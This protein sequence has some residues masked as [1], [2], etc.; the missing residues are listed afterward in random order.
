MLAESSSTP[1]QYG[2][3]IDQ[4][5]RV[6]PFHPRVQAQLGL[7]YVNAGQPK[8][9][10]G[11]LR[12]ALHQLAPDAQLLSAYVTA[13]AAN[14]RCDLARQISRA[15]IRSFSSIDYE[16]LRTAYERARLLCD[17]SAP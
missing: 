13:L 12:S 6:D 5:A 14:Q 4:A 11:Y 17:T 10:L 16:F 15:E 1:Q 7:R 2:I 8:L 9:A 3:A